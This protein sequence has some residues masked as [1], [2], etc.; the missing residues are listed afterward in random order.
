MTLDG[1]AEK[2]TITTEFMQLMHFI[3]SIKN[4]PL[5]KVNQETAIQMVLQE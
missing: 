2:E 5:K 3:A 4:N 1:I